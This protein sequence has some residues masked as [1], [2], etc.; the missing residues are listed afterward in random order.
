MKQRLQI[1][2]IVI[3]LQKLIDIEFYTQVVLCC[4]NKKKTS[5]NKKVIEKQYT[6]TK[7]HL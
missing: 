4:K 1:Y 6:I 3:F 2:Y 5:Y 7:Y